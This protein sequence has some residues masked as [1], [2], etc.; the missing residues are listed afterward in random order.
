MLSIIKLGRTLACMEKHMADENP[1]VCGGEATFCAF[2]DLL[3]G[4]HLANVI[5]E[6]HRVKCG[7]GA[8][9][10]LELLLPW[11]ALLFML[12]EDMLVG[13]NKVT[14]LA[15]EGIMGFTMCLHNLR[16]GEK[17]RAGII[18]ALHCF[19]AVN[20]LDVPQKLLAIF[21]GIN[22]AGLKA[23]QLL[24]LCLVGLQMF[25]EGLA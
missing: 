25:L 7:K 16:R 11:V 22:A 1:L 8:E 21:C 18:L 12:A 4:M 17:Q 9:T 2:V 5:V 3:T 19:N 23:A 13:T 10:A 15:M 6:F 20:L 24:G 14:L